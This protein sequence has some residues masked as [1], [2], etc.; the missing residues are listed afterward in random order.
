MLAGF[1][2][3]YPA[4]CFLRDASPIGGEGLECRLVARVSH[5]PRT[6]GI[7]FGLASAII[8]IHIVRPYY[9]YGDRLQ[10]GNSTEAGD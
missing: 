3:F 7:V 6:R 1:F 10:C 9:T 8:S 5:L 4:L 2:F